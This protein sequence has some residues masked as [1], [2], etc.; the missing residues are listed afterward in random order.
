MERN[1]MASKIEIKDKTGYKVGR[2]IAALS[3]GFSIELPG[4]LY[5]LCMSENGDI[6][7]NY[8]GKCVDS[9]TAGTLIRIINEIPD[10]DWMILMAPFAIWETNHK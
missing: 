2:F 8:G 1:Q 4:T 3:N 7:F 6:G 5:P 10:P 9:F